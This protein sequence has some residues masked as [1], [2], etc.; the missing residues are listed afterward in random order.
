MFVWKNVPLVLLSVVVS[1]I[2]VEAV[3]GDLDSDGLVPGV[4]CLAKPHCLACRLPQLGKLRAAALNKPTHPHP[5][6]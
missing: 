4:G 2:W 5:Q 3:D 6:R 1:W